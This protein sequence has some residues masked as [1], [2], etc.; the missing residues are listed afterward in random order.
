M[1]LSFVN[2]TDDLL[3]QP[4]MP[5]CPCDAFKMGVLMSFPQIDMADDDELQFVSAGQKLAPKRFR[6]VVD[7]NADGLLRACDDVR[8]AGNEPRDVV[9]ALD[10]YMWVCEQLAEVVGP[11]SG[12]V[13][14]GE[15]RRSVWATS[16]TGGHHFSLGKRGTTYKVKNN[17]IMT[18]TRPKARS[19]RGA[20]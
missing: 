3:L 18:P 8:K 2:A 12:V 9:L 13:I 16:N 14:Y 7:T 11:F 4:F 19:R 1:V 5:V 15:L 10:R 6:P 20:A 17:P